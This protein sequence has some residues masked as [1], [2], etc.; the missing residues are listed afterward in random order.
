[1]ERRRRGLGRLASPDELDEP[2][3][4][5]D[6]VRVHEQR[7]EEGALPRAAER[8]RAPVRG[9]FE[10]PEDAEFHAFRRFWHGGHAATRSP[11]VQRL[12]AAG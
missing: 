4:G 10:G 3:R 8:E 9:D 12:L 7:R 5:D 11:H 1:V 2:V 6:L